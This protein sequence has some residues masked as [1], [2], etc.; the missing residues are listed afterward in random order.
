MR[1]MVWLPG[2]DS[3]LGHR[4][5]SPV[6]Y[7]YTTGQRRGMAEGVAQSP[8]KFRAVGTAHPPDRPSCGTGCQPCD[9]GDLPIGSSPVRSLFQT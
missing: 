8:V 9:S 1:C 3:N 2:Q 5:Q 6:C 7:H 4:I